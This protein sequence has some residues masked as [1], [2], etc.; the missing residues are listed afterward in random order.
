MRKETDVLREKNAL[1]K[2]KEHYPKELTRR[3]VNLVTTFS[4][5]LCLYLLMEN[6]QGLKIDTQDVEVW[7]ECRSFGFLNHL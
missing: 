5:E 2:L 4:D 3:F 1:N 7:S 6:L